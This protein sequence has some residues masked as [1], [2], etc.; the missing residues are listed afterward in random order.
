MNLGT[1]S[2][3]GYDSLRA[4]EDSEETKIQD[5]QRRGGH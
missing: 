1:V 5:C 3:C 4:R 2:N